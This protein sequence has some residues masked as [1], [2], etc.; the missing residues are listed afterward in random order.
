MSLKRKIIIFLNIFKHILFKSHAWEVCDKLL[1]WRRDGVSA[2]F[3]AQTLRS[4]IQT[5]LAQLPKEAQ[6]A[7]RDSLL[8]HLT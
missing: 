1:Q 2:Y 7:L 3:A 5:D 6:A 8:A 4:K